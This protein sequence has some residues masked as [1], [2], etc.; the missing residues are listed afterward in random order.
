[1]VQP[2]GLWLLGLGAFV[3]TLVGGLIALKLGRNIRFV[4]GLSAG[5]VVGLALFELIPE[6]AQLRTGPSGL[7]TV[8]L[9]VGAGFCLYMAATQWLNRLGAGASTR[10]LGAAS[11]TL[12]SFFD[13]LSIGLAFKVSPSVGLAVA[14]AVLAHDLCDGVNTISVALRGETPEERRVA[15][16]WLCVN[17]A[18]PLTGIALASLA[19][20]ASSIFAPLAA[21]FAGVFLYIGA[22]ELLPRSL[23]GWRSPLATLPAI[24]GVAS[25]YV[26]ASLT[27]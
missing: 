20:V 21:G 7:R 19:P 6:A 16:R 15:L 25:I 2:F 9:A 26:V 10:H 12:H 3:C 17:A 24:T 5:A 13:G 22:A 11:L 8:M 18:A 14:I 4:T 1:M 27:Q 23:S